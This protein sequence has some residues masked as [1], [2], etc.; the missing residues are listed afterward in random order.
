MSIRKKV[1]LPLLLSMG[2]FGFACAQNM[3]I[4]FNNGELPQSF[5]MADVGKIYFDAGTVQAK[6]DGKITIS[7]LQLS[8]IRSIKFNQVISNVENN[9]VEDVKVAVAGDLLKIFGY[10]P[11]SAQHASLFSLSGM[12]VIDI[13]VLADDAIDVSALPKGVYIFKLGDKTYKICK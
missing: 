7:P 9:L 2:Y 6:K 3:T 1:F 5:K 10:D 11:Q 12:Q 4:N 8:T 13:P